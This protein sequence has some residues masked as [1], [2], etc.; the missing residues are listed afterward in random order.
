MNNGSGESCVMELDV[1]NKCSQCTSSICCTY[2]TQSIDTPRSREDFDL[3]LWKISHQN[4]EI[5]KDEDGWQ[6]QVNNPCMHLKPDGA[7]GIYEDRPKICRDYDNDW[8]EY[9]EPA[10]NN[11]ELN[12]RS[13]DELLVYCKKRFK[14]WA[15]R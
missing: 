10:S 13:Y 7:C 5:Y 8:C 14:T 9:D 11:L 1:K 4:V 6:L 15:S 12:F 2:F 3:L